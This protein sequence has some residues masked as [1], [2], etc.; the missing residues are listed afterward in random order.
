MEHLKRTA[1]PARLCPDGHPPF[2]RRPAAF[3]S[4]RSLARF[5]SGRASRS[6]L[7]HFRLAPPSPIARDAEAC[8]LTN[9][10][11]VMP[12]VLFRFSGP[13]DTGDLY[14]EQAKAVASV[15]EDAT[16]Y[17]HVK[18]AA[19]TPAGNEPEKSITAV[20]RAC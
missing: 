11:L 19:G 20:W 16:V 2:H 10:I 12:Q 17:L 8:G 5:R 15:P 6:S 14:G 18:I 9:K 4:I 7:S 3:G 13:D 1:D